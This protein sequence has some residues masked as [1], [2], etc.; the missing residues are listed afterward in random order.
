[1]LTYKYGTVTLPPQ[2]VL[3]ESPQEH[4]PGCVFTKDEF[5]RVPI[6]C[7]TVKD[8]WARIDNMGHD[9]ESLRIQVT[10]LKAKLYD[11]EHKDDI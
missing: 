4:L 8:L 7:V 10:V 9:V 5:H 11:F 1:M 6:D 2:G 3:V